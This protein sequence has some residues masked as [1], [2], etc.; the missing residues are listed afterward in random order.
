MKESIHNILQEFDEKDAYEFPSN[1]DYD[2]LESR[3]KAVQAGIEREL[4][5]STVFE[6]GHYNQ[7]ASFSI[8]I[9]FKEREKEERNA[10]YQPS[11]RFSN[12]GSMTNIGWEEFFTKDELKRV[13]EILTEHGFTYIPSS[14]LDQPYEGLMEG[15]LDFPNWRTR[16]F[17]WI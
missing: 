3:A 10:I 12:F 17:D 13:K 11:L 15:N 7:D 1:F 6:D 4:N 8:A 9:I 2:S 16:Y 5:E 14:F